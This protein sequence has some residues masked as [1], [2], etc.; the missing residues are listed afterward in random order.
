MGVG[1]LV[2][3]TGLLLLLRTGIDTSYVTDLLPALLLFA[4]GLSMTVAPLVIACGALATELRA[5]LKA[6]GLA[7]AV[8]VTY[9]PA[10]LHNRPERIVPELE[11][12]LDAAAA[13]HRP[14]FVAYAD[15]GTGGALDALLAKHPEATRLPG[16]HCYEFFSGAEQFAAIHEEEL[17]T[18]FLTDFLAKH[19]DA[20]L[21]QG[22]GLDRHPEL[23]DLYFGNYR[24]VVLISQ[25]DSDA[26]VAMGRRCRAV[27][28]VRTSARRH[29][30]IQSRVQHGVAVSIAAGGVMARRSGIRERIVIYWRDIPR[31]SAQEGRD[32][33]QVVLGG[34]FQRAVDRLARPG[35]TPADEE[36]AH[37]AAS[38]L[39]SGELAAGAAA[40]DATNWNTTASTGLLAY[41][42]GWVLMW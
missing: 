9:L 28:G 25:T 8:E 36:V 40:A 33:H 35:S 10:N 21:W 39:I 3:A 18:L 17:G 6:Q 20:L 14:V 37:G 15:C 34:K 30:A 16:S 32:R 7:G 13:Q 41:Y 11:P 5:V 1:P 23:R 12:L 38:R 4:F 26:V 29:G 42:G 2:A 22:L 24:R 31:R 19:F 27:A